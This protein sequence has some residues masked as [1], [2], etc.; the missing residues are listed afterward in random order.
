MSQHVKAGGVGEEVGGGCC[1]Q[2]LPIYS[3]GTEGYG[4]S[5]CLHLT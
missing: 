3:T 1:Q 2:C 5:E 4:D